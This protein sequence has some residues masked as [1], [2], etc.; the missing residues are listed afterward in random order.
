ME[1]F[2]IAGPS[3]F[4]SAAFRHCNA[5]SGSSGSNASS[6]S[7][8]GDDL[9][10]IVGLDVDAL[11]LLEHPGR[12]L[13]F[14]KLAAELVQQRGLLG[15]VVLLHDLLQEFALRLLRIDLFDF[16]PLAEGR[17]RRTPR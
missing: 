15:R 9:V 5:A 13:M 12:G 7:P 10:R 17:Q 3:F 2:L 8:V 11:Q 1:Y 14:R 16:V 4:A 6:L